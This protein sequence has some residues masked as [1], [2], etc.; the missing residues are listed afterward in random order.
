MPKSSE[1]QSKTVPADPTDDP[2]LQ[3][4][5]S[6]PKW[7][8]LRKEWERSSKAWDEN[9]DLL[10]RIHAL[11]VAH[12]V[13]GPD[14]ID[15]PAKLGQ[16]IQREIQNPWVKTIGT[17]LL[18]PKAE[19]A[20]EIAT[21]IWVCD[22]NLP[23]LPKRDADPKVYLV[24]I[25]GWCVVAARVTTGQTLELNETDKAAAD[26]IRKNPGHKGIEVAVAAGVSPEHFR[27]SIVPKLRAHGFYNDNG[28]HPPIAE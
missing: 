25:L 6:D 9:Q 15:T 27:R 22:P 17:A 21:E 3:T 18:K 12:G 14:P 20:R 23:T 5:R 19:E 13:G 26:Y 2:T 24:E 16:W 7:Q 28:Y 4:L 10:Q 8:A 1:V 11:K